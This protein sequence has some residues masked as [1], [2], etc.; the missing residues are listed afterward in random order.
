MRGRKGRKERVERGTKL[1]V[2]D[3]MKFVNVVEDV[4]KSETP[5]DVFT[6]DH[7][8]ATMAGGVQTTIET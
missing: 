4:L 6:I 2:G 8:K 1:M 5:D 3:G 7:A